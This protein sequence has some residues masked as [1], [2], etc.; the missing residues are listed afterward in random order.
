[1]VRGCAFLTHPLFYSYYNKGSLVRIKFPESIKSET[2]LSPDTCENVCLGMESPFRL[3][4]KKEIKCLLFR[5]KFVPLQADYY[6]IRIN[7]SFI[8]S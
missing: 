5:R 6:L 2:S 8:A 1:M 3:K 7:V 4:I